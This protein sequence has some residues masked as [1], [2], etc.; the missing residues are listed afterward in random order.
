MKSKYTNL[1][2][3]RKKI[4]MGNLSN[5]ERL[6]GLFL[7]GLLMFL[8]VSTSA[9][10]ILATPFMVPGGGVPGDVYLFKFEG[11]GPLTE[12]PSI[13]QNQTEHPSYVAFNSMG[14][15]FV[16]NYFG[17]NISRFIRDIDGNFKPS[18]T[19]T[20]NG[21]SMVTGLAFSPSGELFAANYPT[22]LISRF[23]FDAN[24][25]CSYISPIIGTKQ[26]NI[27]RY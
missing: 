25:T 27:H 5:L 8:P 15:L 16:A 21:L 4:R 26:Y 13:P 23:T 10:S 6:F 19:I 11:T 9:E 22:G 24:A 7:I 17:N 20:G 2:T 3:A 12:L 14:E 18:G 1:I